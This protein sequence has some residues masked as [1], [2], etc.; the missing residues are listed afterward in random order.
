MYR[1]I[2]VTNY[3]NA[4]FEEFAVQNKLLLRQNKFFIYA[5]EVVSNTLVFLEIA[6][7]QILIIIVNG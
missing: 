6:C 4:H 7:L 1:F 2:L 3:R 5:S